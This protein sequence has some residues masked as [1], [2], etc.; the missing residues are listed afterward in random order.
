ML[1]TTLACMTR[2]V[3]ARKVASLVIWET[4]D[5]KGVG[6]TRTTNE[7]PAIST[8]TTITIVIGCQ[9]RHASSTSSAVLVL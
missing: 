1:I 3:L 7:V 2:P 5:V 4:V 9:M 6:A 8:F